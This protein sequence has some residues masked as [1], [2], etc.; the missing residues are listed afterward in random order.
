MTVNYESL[1]Y[2][3]FVSAYSA[4]LTGLPPTPYGDS[5][6]PFGGYAVGCRTWDYWLTMEWGKFRPMDAVL[7]VGAWQTFFAL[8]LRQFVNWVDASDNF[9]WEQ[10][11]FVREQNLPSSEDW[12]QTVRSLGGSGVTA[13]N[14]DLQDIIYPNSFAD[15]I[16]CISTIEHVL[17]D[18]KAMAEM[19][20]VLKPGGRLLLTTEFDET[21]GKDYSE[22]DGSWYRVYDRQTWNTLLLPYHVVHQE[23]STQPHQHYFTVAFACIEKE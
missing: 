23:I 9:Y 17:D 13:S 11:S 5:L 18:H 8:Y 14:V 2:S 10:R 7:E 12:E 15:K 21:R 22:S 16:T 3:D 6:A 20:R 1:T 4:F 19:V